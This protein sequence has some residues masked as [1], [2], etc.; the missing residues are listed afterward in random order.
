M[1]KTTRIGL[2]LVAATLLERLRHDTA[3][4]QGGA[5]SPGAAPASSGSFFGNLFGSGLSPALEAQ[6]DRLK[7][8]LSG[9]PVVI[10]TTDDH[11]LR[12]TVPTR[13]A[14][15]PGRAAVKPALGAVLEQVAIGFKPYA[16]TT[17]LRIAAPGDDKAPARLVQERAAAV[18]DE[19][20]ARGVPASRITEPGPASAAG[21]EL[22]LSD[23]PLNK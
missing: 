20:I 22:L 23:R 14:F 18:R 7:Q 6:R 2:A 3:P 8:A 13:H 9:T 1:R 11:R 12:V 15:D 10:D 4:G 19:L 21:L 16:A 17:E 5:R